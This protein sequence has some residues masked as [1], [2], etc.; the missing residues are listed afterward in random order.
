MVVDITQCRVELRPFD[1][2]NVSSVKP[3]M[4]ESL[5][6]NIIKGGTVAF[7]EHVKLLGNIISR[8]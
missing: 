6:H 8:K 7:Q 2:V 4:D 5:S 3:K 1:G